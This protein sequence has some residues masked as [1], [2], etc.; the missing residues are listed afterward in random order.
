MKLAGF[1][2]LEVVVTLAIVVALA[3]LV[4]PSVSGRLGGESSTAMVREI[5]AGVRMARTDAI[6]EAEARRVVFVTD[7]AGRVTRM[8]SRSLEEREAAP[9][10]ARLVGPV[11]DDP[12][13]EAGEESKSHDV[14]LLEMPR[15]TRASRRAPVGEDEAGWMDGATELGTALAGAEPGMLAFEPEAWDEER[16][17]SAVTL[18]VLLPTG[19]AVAGAAVYVTLPDGGALEVR[20]QAWT[21]DALVTRWVAPVPQDEWDAARA[22]GAR[23]ADAGAASS[24]RDGRGTGR[25]ASE[26]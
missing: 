18:G 26:R 13:P 20:L 23:D 9:A 22:G 21:G 12:A 5:A 14:V 19:A 6:R 15:G 17:E 7:A 2:L 8:V 1:T 10:R 4:V 11:L 25:S 16:G 3:S 24:V